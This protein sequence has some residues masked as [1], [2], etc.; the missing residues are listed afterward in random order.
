MAN[1][2]A[3][4]ITRADELTALLEFAAANGYDG[5]TEKLKKVLE[6][7]TAKTG[8]TS[9]TA[10]ANNELAAT[11]YDLMEEDICYSSKEVMALDN[12]I[13]TVSKAA[14]I[15]RILIERGEVEKSYNGKSVIYF[16]RQ[17][18]RE[19]EGSFYSPFFLSKLIANNQ[20]FYFNFCTKNIIFYFK[21]IKI[22]IFYFIFGVNKILLFIF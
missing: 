6:Q 2:I 15:M 18:Q 12:R 7:W 1:A 10:I 13:K 8:K 3:T 17:Q 21:L 22:L 4:R 9:A 11:V 16:R 19:K 14:V 5:S 20:Y